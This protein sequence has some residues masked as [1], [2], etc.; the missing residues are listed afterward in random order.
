MKNPNLAVERVKNH[1]AYQLGQ[2]MI[3]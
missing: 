2:V 1:L 3:E